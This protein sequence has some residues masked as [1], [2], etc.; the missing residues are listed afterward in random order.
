MK[1]GDFF[2]GEDIKQEIEKSILRNG[3]KPEYVISNQAI[4]L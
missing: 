4:I 1:S 2:K 3:A